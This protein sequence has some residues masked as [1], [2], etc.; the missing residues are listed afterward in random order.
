MAT[1]ARARHIYG[2]PADSSSD[3]EDVQYGP[4]ANAESGTAHAPHATPDSP[5][6]PRPW[7]EHEAEIAAIEARVYAEGMDRL[8]DTLS[9]ADDVDP[10]GDQMRLRSGRTVDRSRAPPV[11]RRTIGRQHRVRQPRSLGWW[12]RGQRRGPPPPPSPPSP[13]L[14]DDEEDYT[15][16]RARAMEDALRAEAAIRREERRLER[17][18]R[19]E[20]NGDHYAGAFDWIDGDLDDDDEEDDR[21]QAVQALPNP[22]GF[23]QPTEELRLGT[24]AICQE[25][26]APR[27][28]V[29]QACGH[30]STCVKCTFELV[31][32]FG[33]EPS[34]GGNGIAK[35]PVCRVTSMPIQL[36]VA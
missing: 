16:R 32:R 26:D 18:E 9:D 27:S 21:P 25:D 17:R 29:F 28:V 30:V 6:G 34:Y 12:R 8:D 5:D 22:D 23:C 2:T 19:A 20:A 7:A 31:K 10:R 13:Q 1:G 3:E 35:C 4:F 11:I 33:G 14:T 24:C 15:F 36:R